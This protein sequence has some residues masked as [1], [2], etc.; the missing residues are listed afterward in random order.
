MARR[1]TKSFI[2]LQD[3]CEDPHKGNSFQTSLW[4]WS[5][6]TCRS[7]YGKPQGDEVSEQG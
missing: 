4:K 3:D 1:A 2:G 6:D 5:S 7:A